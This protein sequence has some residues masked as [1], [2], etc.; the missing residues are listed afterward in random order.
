M[1]C[2]AHDQ[3]VIEKMVSMAPFSIAVVQLQFTKFSYTNEA[4]YD[5][6]MVT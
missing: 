4:R 2:E 1:E 6:M 3:G 5:N